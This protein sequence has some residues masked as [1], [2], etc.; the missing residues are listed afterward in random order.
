MSATVKQQQEKIAEQ[1]A[2]LAERKKIQFRQAGMELAIK[3]STPSVTTP[4]DVLVAA[5]AFAAFLEGTD[6][7]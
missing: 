7:E 2:E 3:F 6:R 1:Q 5:K 4:A